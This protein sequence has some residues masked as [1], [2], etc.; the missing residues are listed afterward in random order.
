MV[1]HGGDQQHCGC[2]QAGH[3]GAALLSF[4]SPTTAELATLGSLSPGKMQVPF[5]HGSSE[6]VEMSAWG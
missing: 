6:Q 4:S 5:K 3:A 1:G 2:S